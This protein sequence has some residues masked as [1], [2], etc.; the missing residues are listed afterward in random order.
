MNSIA[1]AESGQQTEQSQA[2]RVAVVDD[3]AVVR[4]LV[5]RWVDEDPDLEV[6]GKF[7]NGQLAV[8]GVG[9]V[10]PDVIILDIEMPVMD[11]LTALPRL[12]ENAPNA[13]VIIASTLSR[14]NAE[15][16]LK[17]LS[18]GATDYIPKPE[19][20]RGITTSTEFREELLRKVKAVV[21]NKGPAARA[22]EAR[23]G[24]APTAR[25]EPGAV[26]VGEKPKYTLRA[27]STVRPKI[28]AIGSS[29]GGPQALAKVIEDIA[30]AI[31]L[32][33]V[34]ITQH[35]PATFTAILAERLGRAANL[36]AKEG[37]DGE[38]L[39]PG[40]I[41]IAPGGF[42]MTV[43]AKDGQP[44]ISVFDGP[45]I[46]FCKPAVDPMFE[47]VAKLYGRSALALVL[48]GMGH[49]GAS[50]GKFVA[51]AGGSVIAQDQASSVVW[52]M[53]GATAAAGACAAVL[54][55]NRIGPKVGSLLSGGGE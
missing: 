53:P 1:L 24:R 50:G 28:V 8:D 20:N 10:S 5:S 17:A 19:T 37:E 27:F 23:S 39:R 48:T 45:Q 34:V 49:D 6:C 26:E 25:A 55:L 16:S 32:V 51:D 35:M 4:G 30:P 52:G 11:G 46:N 38:P 22:N 40:H 42:H 33:P 2:I 29:T 15:I 21:P 43:V 12:L 41:Y 54:P 9:R 3:S 36:P 44:F 7:S 47:S 18:L 13:K 31:T 14:K